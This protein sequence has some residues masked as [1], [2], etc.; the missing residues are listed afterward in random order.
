GKSETRPG[1][2][3][4]HVTRILAPAADRR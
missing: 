2:K 3:M 4:G 1:R